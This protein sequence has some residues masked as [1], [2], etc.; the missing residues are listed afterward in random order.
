MD[1]ITPQ[2]IIAI[3]QTSENSE[4]WNANYDEICSR[5]GG[6]KLWWKTIMM[7]GIANQIQS[8]WISTGMSG[9]LSDV[10]PKSNSGVVTIELHPPT[11]E[12]IAEIKKYPA[13]WWNED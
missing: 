11:D 4:Q 13:N 2:E 1:N 12:E 8:R 3:M 6:G 9:L 10:M 5:G 7:S